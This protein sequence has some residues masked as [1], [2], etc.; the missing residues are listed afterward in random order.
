M[1]EPEHVR[2]WLDDYGVEGKHRAEQVVA[3][4]DEVTRRSDADTRVMTHSEQCW[5]WHTA[6]L[7]AR[8]RSILTEGE[9]T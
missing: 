3:I 6:C 7:A 4:C 8:I 5:Q 2:Q 1:P 9:Q